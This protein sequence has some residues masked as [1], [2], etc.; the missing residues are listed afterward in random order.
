MTALPVAAAAASPYQHALDRGFSTLRFEPLLE[1]EFQRF[2]S[3][4]NLARVRWSA[5][6]AF[7][8]YGVFVA[9]DILTLPPDVHHWTAPIRAFAIM[10]AFLWVIAATYRDAWQPRMQGPITLAATMAGLGTVLLIAI[11]LRARHPLPYEGIL[12]VAMFIYLLASLGWWRA[13]AVNLATLVAL[14]G[15]E[16]AWQ[17]DP[18]AR[19]Y[20]IVF[21]LAANIVGATGAYFLEHSTRAV[22]LVQRLLNERA[23]HDGLTGL[24]NRAA[25]DEHLARIWRQALRERAA[26]AIAMVDVDHF[27]RYNDRYG[28]AEGDVA[29]QAVAAA[30]GAQARRPLDLAARYGGEEFMLVWYRPLDA[31]LATL[32]EQVRAAIEALRIPHAEGEGGVLTAS[33]GIACVVPTPTHGPQRLMEA[34]DAALYAAKQAGRNGVHIDAGVALPA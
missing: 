19:L 26:V 1:R 10:P 34:A 12:L 5:W 8:L 30:V 31:E 25:L 18:Q 23:S 17:I 16:L 29:L 21:M 9:I 6:L 15:A 22:F 2:H 7:V 33:V 28:H 3:R 24:A 32:G 4:V 27:K 11:G 14:I 13:L 20:Q